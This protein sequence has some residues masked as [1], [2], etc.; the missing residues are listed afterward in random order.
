MWH[1]VV[2]KVPLGGRP[3]AE[4]KVMGR[5]WVNGEMGRAFQKEKYVGENTAL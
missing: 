3:S 1:V 2:G 4:S 5:I